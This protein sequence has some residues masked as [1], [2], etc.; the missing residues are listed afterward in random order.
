MV[1]S[2][3]EKVYIYICNK[4]VVPPSGSGGGGG[5]CSPEQKS[6]TGP[7]GFS[8]CQYTGVVYSVSCFLRILLQ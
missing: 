7:R 8:Q 2:M 5:E 6:E 4:D 3:L 1:R